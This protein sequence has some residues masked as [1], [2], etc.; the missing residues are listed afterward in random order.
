MLG[1]SSRSTHIRASH[2]T[3]LSETPTCRLLN[4]RKPPPLPL[5]LSS[6]LPAF[7]PGLCPSLPHGDTG[8]SLKFVFWTMR[9]WTWSGFKAAKFPSYRSRTIWPPLP[10]IPSPFCHQSSLSPCPRV[11]AQAV[12]FAWTYLL[13]PDSCT[14]SFPCLYVFRH[15][16]ALS[17]NFSFGIIKYTINYL[18]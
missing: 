14:S 6:Y 7:L 16:I 2:N 10:P 12:S 4:L 17:M 9:V 8:L 5:P 1:H 11:F 3:Y 15:Y 18:L 13:P